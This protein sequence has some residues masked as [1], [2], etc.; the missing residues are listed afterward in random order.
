M[1][2]IFGR[3]TAGEKKKKK[4][5]EQ[6]LKFWGSCG[7]RISLHTSARSLIRRGSSAPRK[8][9]HELS[10]FKQI[11]AHTSPSAGGDCSEKKLLEVPGVTFDHSF[12]HIKPLAAAGAWSSSALLWHTKLS[13]LGGE[14]ESERL[15][16]L[17]VRCLEQTPCPEFGTRTGRF[18]I[19]SWRQKH[20]H[21]LQSVGKEN[22]GLV[23]HLG[24]LKLQISGYF[25][26]EQSWFLVLHWICSLLL[27]VKVWNTNFPEGI[28][29]WSPPVD[30]QKGLMNF[31]YLP[32]QKHILEVATLRIFHLTH[33]SIQIFQ[34]FQE[35]RWV[36][37]IKGW[38]QRCVLYSMKSLC[39]EQL[40]VQIMETTSL[41]AAI[42]KRGKK[43]PP[44]S[45]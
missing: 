15:R 36:E 40:K 34:L 37:C 19:N 45:N 43:T 3:L 11:C 8:V 29:T 23:L 24:T 18:G 22:F 25:P 9:F 14:M 27:R 7:G 30:E 20:L 4:E 16:G 42:K 41:K 26:S 10:S 12:S 13:S 21:K 44:R 28:S 39:S 32:T 17:K 31:H 5:R 35:L 6:I 38:R 33:P 1:F 2:E